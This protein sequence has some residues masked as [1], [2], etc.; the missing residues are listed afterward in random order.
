MTFYVKTGYIAAVPWMSGAC[1]ICPE[2]AISYG[3]G[4]RTYE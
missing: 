3:V 2:G 1:L 4:G